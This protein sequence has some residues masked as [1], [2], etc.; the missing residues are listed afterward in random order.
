[1]AVPVFHLRRYCG[2]HVT[3]SAPPPQER[4][5]I[6]APEG[7]RTATVG[8]SGSAAAGVCRD[9]LVDPRLVHL[10]LVGD[11]FVLGPDEGFDL[12]IHVRRVDDDKACLTLFK[13]V[14]D[15]LQVRVLHAASDVPCR[16][17][18][19]AAGGHSADEPDR[20]EH[21]TGGADSESPLEPVTGGLLVLA[22]DVALALGITL[23]H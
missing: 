15:L 22:D 17:A 19:R 9:L 1:M 12:I 11:V 14:C 3:D 4:I 7:M 18:D 10:H 20:R 8:P 5:D 16:R 13:G 6:D 2:T 23:N 21:G